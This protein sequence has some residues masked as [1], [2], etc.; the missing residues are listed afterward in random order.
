MRSAY[1]AHAAEYDAAGQRGQDRA[2][3]RGMGL[4]GVNPAVE[5]SVS[6]DTGRHYRD[7]GHAY[8]ATSLGQSA[9]R[10]SASRQSVSR[11]DRGPRA[12][13]GQ[14]ASGPRGA[15]PTVGDGTWT[16][17]ADPAVGDGP[18]FMLGRDVILKNPAGERST[19]GRTE[20]AQAPVVCGEKPWPTLGLTAELDWARQESGRGPEMGFNTGVDLGPAITKG[21]GQGGERSKTASGHGRKGVFTEESD[22]GNTAV[23]LGLVI[24]EGMGQGGASNLKS[25]QAKESDL[26]TNQISSAKIWGPHHSL[27][28]LTF[29]PGLGLSELLFRQCLHELSEFLLHLIMKIHVSP[30]PPI[31]WEP[32]SSVHPSPMQTTQSSDTN[33]FRLTGFSFD[34]RIPRHPLPLSARLVHRCEMRDR[35]PRGRVRHVARGWTRFG[36]VQPKRSHATERSELLRKLYQRYRHQ[37][38]EIKDIEFVKRIRKFLNH[39]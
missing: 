27:T 1:R 36:H 8:R 30:S 9:P 21:M 35:V 37:Q 2:V 19:L 29:P 20:E 11:E 17:G 7:P 38:Q 28:R 10:Q 3:G 23:D 32:K 15:D 33:P 34:H 6:Q 39:F 26:A 13:W 25:E 16:R 4:R 31:Q 14:G 18:W 12:G 22:Y 24:T 5:G